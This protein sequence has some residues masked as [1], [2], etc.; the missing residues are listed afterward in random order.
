MMFKTVGPDEI[1]S[2]GIV[3]RKNRTN[4]KAQRSSMKFKVS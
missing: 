4:D 2:G 1:I 3:E